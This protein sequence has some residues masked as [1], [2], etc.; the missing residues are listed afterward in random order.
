MPE[1]PLHTVRVLR[2]FSLSSLLSILGAAGAVRA[3][4]EPRIGLAAPQRFEHAC[5]V[6]ESSIA[7][8]AG[9]SVL[10]RGGNAVDAA[11]AT[12]FALAVVHPTAGNVGGGGFLVVR[13]PDGSATTFDFREAAPLA[14]RPDIFLGAD[15]KYDSKRHHWSIFA[16][17][18]PGSVAGLHLAHER[19]G[20]LPWKDLVQPAIELA[21]KGFPVSRGLAESIEDVLP[22]M[23]PY[24]AS[25]AQFTKD[26]RPLRANDLLVQR[27][28]ARTLERV[29]DRGPSGFYKGETADLIVKEM[30]R[31][32]GL[33]RHED[34]KRYRAVERKPVTGL[35]RGHEIIGMGPPSS[36]G[37]AIIEMLNILEG[38][39]LRALGLRGSR[40]SHLLAEAM[41]R[42][43]ADRARFLGDPDRTDVP[44]ARLTSKEH[45]AGLR[46]SIDL[47]RASKSSPASFE[48]PAE[49]A[50]TTHLS[51]VDRDLM[52]AAL[53]TTIEQSYGSR[54]VVPG[55]GFL[56]NNEMGDFNPRD[57]LTTEGGLIGTPPNLVEPGKRMLSSMSPVI[58]VREGKPLLVAGS[59]G[60]RTIINTV[61]EV[62][63]NFIDHRLAIQDAVDAPRFHEQWLPDRIL[64]EPLCFSPDVRA[65]LEAMGH[66]IEIGGQ[67]GSAM[68]IAI[69]PG[70]HLEAGVDRRRPDTGAAGF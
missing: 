28:L 62:L 54:I 35:Y 32:G 53:T 55:A 61:V 48:W 18:V 63:V 27:D 57:G 26:G 13:S 9:A 41:R 68:A 14:S 38:H 22:S 64:A 42:A 46:K 69:E 56:L 43:F 3:A 30:E 23:K 40:E 66:R 10:E 70:K 19:L 11:I 29:R 16:V 33:I 59:P 50:Q 31:Q 15:G 49:G 17:G 45:A 44:V 47:A 2:R 39:D 25:I 6:S 1:V 51:V 52:A 34:L 67:Q 20:K 58:V 7:S 24:P 12:A 65:A 60:G 5:V 37:I 4:D 21:E 8:K 36:G